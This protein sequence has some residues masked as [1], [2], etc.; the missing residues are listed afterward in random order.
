MPMADRIRHESSHP[1]PGVE[2]AV[3]GSTRV[4]PPV[5]DAL[6]HTDPA[7][8]HAVPRDDVA[9]ATLARVEDLLGK[10]HF[11]P[12]L[13]EASGLEVASG[14]LATRYGLIQQEKVSRAQ[15]GIAN[16]YFL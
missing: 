7:L 6:V 16:R 8:L 11:G 1:P 12:A 10:G 9:E 5:R 4:S 2:A 13:Q 15:I 14:P 3:L